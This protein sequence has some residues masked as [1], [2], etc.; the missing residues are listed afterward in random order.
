MTF[1][2]LFENTD[3]KF[4]VEYLF[5][6][7]EDDPVIRNDFLS[8]M[9][10]VKRTE[11]S[12]LTDYDEFKEKISRSYKDYL[13][14]ID[15]IN[16]EA[17]DWDSYVP[18]HNGYVEEW[19]AYET[20]AE[21]EVDSTIEGF[22]D[23]ILSL[24]IQGD[25][26]GLFCE[27]IAF[28]NAASD[29]DISNP[30]Y[31]LGEDPGG[32]II[33]YKLK[34]WLKNTSKRVKD[35]NVSDKE[36]I[37][38]IKLFLKFMTESGIKKHIRLFEELLLVLSEKVNNKKQLVDLYD[39][40]KKHKKYFPKF[41]SSVVKYVDS[42]NWEA[43]A[44]DVLLEDNSVGK[45]LLDKYLM[46]NEKAKYIETAKKLFKDDDVYWAERIVDHILPEDDKQFYIDV[47]ISC[48]TYK[49]KVEYYR[50]IKDMLSKDDKENLIKLIDYDHLLK[51][52]IWGEEGEYDKIKAEMKE[53]TG[54]W[55]LK[56]KMID[57]VKDKYPDFAFDIIAEHV[58][59]LMSGFK[60]N[61]HTYEKIAGWLKYSKSISGQ[62]HKVNSLISQLY[63]HKPNLPALKDE[64]R[65]AG[66]V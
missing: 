57:V 17:F 51:V 19:E 64:F 38:S 49:S 11:Q 40:I 35:V 65:M 56:K 7:L 59:K 62:D 37:N 13:S 43:T 30:Y 2:E 61:R 34:E 12:A 24:I 21:Q 60:R 50:K 18:P 48:C 41:T 10:A 63:N 52:K 54:S 22:E 5:R 36:I 23:E 58:G 6:L 26:T 28:L 15:K 29:S 25:I 32:Y 39:L 3:D 9:P 53:L 27:L 14:L 31:T 4:K 45:E 47:N 55:N 42:D 46:E 44:Q 33:D 8:K 16:L 20:M 1:K 66:I